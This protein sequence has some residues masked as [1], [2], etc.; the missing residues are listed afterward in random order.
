[1]KLSEFSTDKA[2]DIL[3]EVSVYTLNILSDEE[4]RESLK[5]L[6]GDEKPQTVGERYAIGVQ[7]IGQWIP[8]LLK[9][10]KEDAFGVLAAVN[11]VTVDA[12]REQNVL[13]TMRQIRAL[14]EDK[15]LTDFFKSCA[16][17]AK[18]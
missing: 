18:A 11:G 15:D 5:K 7:R 4:F 2:V 16:S 14:A 10:H 17:G 12:V 8:L 6:T 9:K 13:T 1:M 3:C